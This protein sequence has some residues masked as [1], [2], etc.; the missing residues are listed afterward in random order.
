MHGPSPLLASLAQRPP[1]PPMQFAS[2]AGMALPPVADWPTET[3]RAVRGVPRV[4][5]A[6]VEDA[7]IAEVNAR[8]VRPGAMLHG[9]PLTLNGLQCMALAA[10]AHARGAVLPI[11]TG[12]GKT[13][14]AIL[15]GTVLGVDHTMILT[16]PNVVAQTSRW[17]RLAQDLFFIE[18]SMQCKSYNWVSAVGNSR[19]LEQLAKNVGPGRLA[20]VCDE[21]H[22]LGD[23][24]AARTRRFGRAVK[25]G[26]PVV[27]MSGTLSHDS[28]QQFC[29]IAEWA[30]GPRSFLPRNSEPNHEHHVLAWSACLDRRGRPASQ[31]WRTIGPLLEVFGDVPQPEGGREL[32][33]YA[34]RAFQS[35]MRSA[36][37]V[38]CSSE[39][40]IGTALT[41][42]PIEVEVPARVQSL[43]DQAMDASIDPEGEI[44]PDDLSRARVGTHLSLG[45]YQKWRWP[46]GPDGQAIIDEEWV[47]S[48]RGWNK[49]VRDELAERAGPDY[50]SEA[51]VRARIAW[52]AEALNAYDWPHQAL[53]RWLPQRP[54]PE[55]PSVPTWVDLFLVSDVIDRVIEAER[56]KQHVIVWY[57][58]TALEGPLRQAGLPVYGR[59]STIP[60][61]KRQSLAASWNVHKEGLD[62][63]Q[64]WCSRNLVVEPPSSGAIWEQM[65]ARTHRPGQV[66]DE[67][68]V[69]VYAHTEPFRRALRS[70]MQSAWFIEE[71]FGT[72]QKLAMATWT[73]PV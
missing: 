36:P 4:D 55:P 43:L 63:L 27:A 56:R 7:L 46:L 17:I 6:A 16:K 42:T 34:R 28:I 19:E 35:R 24:D 14:I 50:D 48:R 26:V 2:L 52:E 51:L 70:A 54:K 38:V 57:G 22:A 31:D 37:G 39:S 5:Y 44:L 32:I 71:S 41:I 10:I 53:S 64:H 29:H 3:V 69:L 62:G 45:F 8:L 66:R 67:V 15:A 30:L 18:G 72:R 60:T 9:K 12:G 1:R 23:M 33:S 68:E 13:F 11:G 47:R 65:I 49:V 58:S 59:G 73:S 21:A 61:D 20:I 25:S 40:S